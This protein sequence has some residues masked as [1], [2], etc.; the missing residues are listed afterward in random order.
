MAS[1]AHGGWTE[2]SCGSSF[3]CSSVVSSTLLFS[4]AWWSCAFYAILSVQDSRQLIKNLSYKYSKCLRLITTW[5]WWHSFLPS[6]C[7][8][9]TMSQKSSAS[10]RGLCQKPLSRPRFIT[11]ADAIPHIACRGHLETKP[12]GSVCNGGTHHQWLTPSPFPLP[13]L[14]HH[15]L[16]LLLAAFPS[17]FLLVSRCLM[18]FILFRVRSAVYFRAMTNM[19]R[20]KKGATD[21]RCST[22]PFNAVVVTMIFYIKWWNGVSRGLQQNW[23]VAEK[24]VWQAVVWAE[25]ERW[26][27]KSLAWQSSTLAEEDSCISRMIALKSPV[28]NRRYLCCT[29]LRP[30]RREPLFIP[31]CSF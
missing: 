17:Q 27:L 29:T 6:H 16:D 11:H 18:C 26:N 28:W 7:R 15:L 24:L 25:V 22:R 9:L 14:V 5:T 19:Q 20:W 23:T 2:Y 13:I 1:P 8:C 30:L 12:W 3:S 21:A 10:Y 4:A 31:T